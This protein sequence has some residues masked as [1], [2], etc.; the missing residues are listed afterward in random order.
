MGANQVNESEKRHN[1][2]KTANHSVVWGKTRVDVNNCFSGSGTAWQE[3]F[4]EQPTLSIVTEEIGGRCEARVRLDTEFA[5]PRANNRG[6]ASFIP[7]GMQIWGYSSHIRRIRE[8]RV[9]FA[10]DEIE[11]V[12]EANANGLLR[13]PRL[14]LH[15]AE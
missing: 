5:K 2:T 1:I 13:S 4:A 10:E 7:A 11:A 8:V 3:L 15:D 6:H 12:F 14:M 9:Y